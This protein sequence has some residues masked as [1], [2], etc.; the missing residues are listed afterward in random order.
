MKP[1]A[2]E[3]LRKGALVRVA[4]GPEDAGADVLALAYLDLRFEDGHVERWLG[5]GS[6]GELPAGPGAMVTLQAWA[7]D[8]VGEFA[9]DIMCDVARDHDVSSPSIVDA[10]PCDEV[11]V[12]WRS[13]WP[14][15]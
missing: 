8:S 12:E 13:D 10:L 14:H 6:T 4:G 11:V 5:P 7:R 2:P 3:V 15:G 9:F 1:A